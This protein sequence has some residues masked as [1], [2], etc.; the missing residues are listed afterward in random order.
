[1]QLNQDF[2]NFNFDN[3]PVEPEWNFP[4]LKENKMHKIHSYPAKF[5][6]FITTKAIDYAKAKGVNV[7]LIADIFC[8]CGTSAFEA[9]RSGINYWGCDI[10]PV[11]TLIAETKS[12]K[13]DDKKL[14]SYF[15]KISK[16][17][18]KIKLKKNEIQ[19]INSR[20]KYWYFDEQIEDLIK[21]KKSI[22]QSIPSN[23]FYKKFFLCAFSN[24]LKS[25][26]K[27]LTKSIKPTIDPN[28]IPANV[29]MKF[30]RQILQ[31]LKANG[32]NQKMN[33]CKISI[34]NKNFLGLNFEKSF[35]DLVVTSPPYVTSYE[36]A[37]LHQLSSLWLGYT[38]DF[39]SLRKGSIGSLYNESNFNKDVK[40]LNKTGEKIVF[41]LYNQ[42]KRKSKSAAKY[43]V[44]MQESIKRVYKIL[45]NN[46]LALFVI[47]NTEY[48]GVKINNAKHLAECLLNE[49]FINIEVSKRKISNKFLTPYRDKGGKFS[50]DKR[51][52]KIYSE[53]F[54]ITARKIK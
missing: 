14:N 10:N 37:D 47:G 30:N 54:I 8:G 12:R 51:S 2:L 35:A 41:K 49:G 53:E 45:N 25:T 42:D 38:D 5:P 39:K 4:K 21:L 6:A 19:N 31:M 52:R 24:I 27:W 46:G 17:F 16:T 11:A 32:E 28:K 29:F 36:Y 50:S 7:K 1:M 22:D 48:K 3:I 33:K 13:Y 9:A 34:N 26:S 40:T 20:I 15:D 43:Y 18:F 44:D 23:S